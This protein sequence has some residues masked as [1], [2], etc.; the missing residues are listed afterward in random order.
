MMMV[1]ILKLV[2]LLIEE[3]NYELKIRGVN[4]TRDI[5]AKRK[6]LARTFEKERFRL[7]ELT[8][9]TIFIYSP[10]R[11]VL[12]IMSDFVVLLCYTLTTSW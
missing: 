10:T 5:S 9:N 1:D 3:L 12:T 2:H 8:D 11:N 4:T 7:L 6:I